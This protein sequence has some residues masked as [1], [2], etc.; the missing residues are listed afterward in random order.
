MSIQIRADE[1]KRGDRFVMLGVAGTAVVE[2]IERDGAEWF[3]RW[4][5]GGHLG[6][7]HARGDD[8]TFTVSRDLRLR[9][10]A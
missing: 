8:G 7:F 2:K 9:A 10:V 5:A 1:V 3:V 4:K 6:S